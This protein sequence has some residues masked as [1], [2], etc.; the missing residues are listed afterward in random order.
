MGVLFGARD[1]TSICGSSRRNWYVMNTGAFT[2]RNT[3]DMSCN[4]D[5]LLQFPLF[6]FAILGDPAQCVVSDLAPFAVESTLVKT[7][8]V[9]SNDSAGMV[10]LRYRD[11]GR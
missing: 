1:S 11:Y 2:D 3:S 5:T 7:W 6:E 4:M 9:L 8:H 10:R